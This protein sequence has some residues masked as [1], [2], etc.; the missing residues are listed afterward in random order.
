MAPGFLDSFPDRQC[1]RADGRR[2]PRGKEAVEPGD[3]ES[4]SGSCAAAL[5]VVS[6]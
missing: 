1:R 5:R 4:V 3:A 6:L 2:D